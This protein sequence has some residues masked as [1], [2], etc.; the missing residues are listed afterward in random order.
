MKRFW[1][2]FLGITLIACEPTA[3]PRVG[4]AIG[5]S[6]P[7]AAG[8]AMGAAAGNAM[9]DA[10]DQTRYEYHAQE[11]N[12]IEPGKNGQPDKCVWP[13]TR[14]S[15]AERL[16]CEAAGGNIGATD[17]WDSS[18]FC[19]LPPSDIGKACEKASDCQS[20]CVA[21][22]RQCAQFPG[23]KGLVLG[24]DGKPREVKLVIE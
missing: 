23:P 18:E 4:T 16:K 7:A 1:P 21:D 11:C 10:G 22:T 17:N 20:V 19:Y 12:A 24:E 3:A 13:A 8:V 9:R 5:V 2:V 6:D 15:A 14:L